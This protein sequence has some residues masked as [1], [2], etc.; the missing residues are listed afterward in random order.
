MSKRHV[1]PKPTKIY[2]EIIDAN[3]SYAASFGDKAN[4]ALPPRLRSNH[5]RLS[6]H[7][8]LLLL[9]SWHAGTGSAVCRCP[10]LAATAT[11]SASH[12]EANHDARAGSAAAI[13]TRNSNKVHRTRR[14]NLIFDYSA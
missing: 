11:S 14:S 8:A 6:V 7:A 1:E 5:C 2:D 10:R 3:Q 4:L 9:L 12:R 13:A